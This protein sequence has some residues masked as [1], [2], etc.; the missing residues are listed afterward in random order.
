LLSNHDL[1]I[2]AMTVWEIDFYRCPLQDEAGNSLW[3]WVVCDAAGTWHE[4][5]FCPQSQVNVNWVIQQLQLL[6]QRHPQPSAIRVFR[7]QTQNVLEAACQQLGIALHPTRHTPQLKQYL[8]ELAAKRTAM[9]SQAQPPYQPLDLDRPPPMPLDESLLGQ[10]WQFA[11]LPASQVVEAFTDR[12][13]P[14]LDIPE[15]FHPL[16]LGLASTMPVPGV[17]I[18]GGRRSLRLAQ[19]IQ[20]AQPVALNY[21]PGSPDGL[22]LEAGLVDRWILA[23]FDDPDVAAAA[24]NF[25][26][27]KQ[28]SQ[29]LHFLLVQPDDTGM[30]FSGYWL[31]KSDLI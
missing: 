27:R 16:Q 13:I 8:Q 28:A 14:I 18:Q 20:S 19:W 15:A 17:I 10:Q 4:Q 24:T 22:I 25:E 30:T 1:L 12:M 31:M 2:F 5:A 3:E 21:I 23:T 11:S 9:L 7:P 26:H 29:G 6:W